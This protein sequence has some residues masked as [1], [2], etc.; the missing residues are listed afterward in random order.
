MLQKRRPTTI[1]DSHHPFGKKALAMGMVA[2][3]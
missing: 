2:V 3:V 1:F